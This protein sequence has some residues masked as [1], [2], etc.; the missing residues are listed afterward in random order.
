MYAWALFVHS[1]V[2]SFALLSA[3]KIK[4]I[5]IKAKVSKFDTAPT[6][7]VKSVSAVIYNEHFNSEQENSIH[8]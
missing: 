1:A 2:I 8:P 4:F 5:W 3:C 6:Y 7:T